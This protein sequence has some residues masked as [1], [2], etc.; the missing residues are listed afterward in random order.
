MPPDRLSQWLTFARMADPPHNPVMP[1]YR[2]TLQPMP[3][4]TA[5]HFAPLIA[6]TLGVVALAGICLWG[7]FAG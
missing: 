6:I 3:R 7:V 4:S 2:R 5:R 1:G